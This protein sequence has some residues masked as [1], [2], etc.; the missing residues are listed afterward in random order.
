[1]Q[2]VMEAEISLGCHPRDVS[3][4]KPGYDIESLDPRNGRLR[5]IEV[6]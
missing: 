5:F 3:K 2:A 4:E 1:M 6:A